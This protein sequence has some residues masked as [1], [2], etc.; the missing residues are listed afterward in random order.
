MNSELD[1]AVALRKL[2]L[3]DTEETVA[4]EPELAKPTKPS[5]MQ[6]RTV[7][8]YGR[9]SVSSP[10]VASPASRAAPEINFIFSPDELCVLTVRNIV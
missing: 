10:P 2:A 8:A 5:S 4:P 1:A 3:D 7:D 9:A 6:T